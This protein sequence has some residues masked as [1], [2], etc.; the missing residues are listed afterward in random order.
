MAPGAARREYPNCDDWYFR[1]RAVYAHLRMLHSGDS[2][3]GGVLAVRSHDGRDG[4]TQTCGQFRDIPGRRDVPF[5][6][7]DVLRK[8]SAGAFV[9]GLFSKGYGPHRLPRY[10]FDIN[11]TVPESALPLEKMNCDILILASEKDDVLPAEEAARR[12]E[13]AIRTPDYPHPCGNAAFLSTG[14]H[15]LGCTI[16]EKRMN[17]VSRSLKAWRLRPKECAEALADSQRLIIEFFDR[18]SMI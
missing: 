2:L 9:K 15:I 13:E 11:G 8:G 17:K 16:S 6:P 10:I 14:C 1:G 3:R 5:T 12:I 4:G 7:W 18:A